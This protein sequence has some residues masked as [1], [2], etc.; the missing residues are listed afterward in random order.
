MANPGDIRAGGA[1][2]EIYA[3]DSRFQ[4][5]IDKAE[6]RFK[7]L[8]A[9]LDKV[10]KTFVASGVA[11]GGAL[12]FATKKTVA[13]SDTIRRSELLFGKLSESAKRFAKDMNQSLGFGEGTVLGRL[14]KANIALQ[15]VGFSMDQLSQIGQSFFVRA[16]GLSARIGDDVQQTFDALIMG[17][18]GMTRGLRRYGIMVDEVAMKHRAISMGIASGNGELTQQQKSVAA[19]SLILEKTKGFIGDSVKFQNT[20][21][22]RTQRLKEAWTDFL[23]TVGMPFLDILAKAF[24]ATEALVRAANRFLGE[25]KQ[26]IIGFA[27]LAAII[28]GIGVGILAIL[29]L[30]LIVA[31]AKIAAIFA[32]TAA[33]VAYTVDELQGPMT[34]ALNHIKG[35]LGDLPGDFKEA[36]IA[37]LDAIFWHAAT[38]VNKTIDKIMTIPRLLAEAVSGFHRGEQAGMTGLSGI[39]GGLGG[40]LG[41]QAMSALHGMMGLRA[42]QAAAFA[43]TRQ[44]ST[45]AEQ[46]R[47]RAFDRLNQATLNLRKSGTDFIGRGRDAFDR[48]AQF[49]KGSMPSFKIPGVGDPNLMIPSMRARRPDPELGVLGFFGGRSAREQAG[50]VQDIQQKQLETQGSMLDALRGIEKNTQQN[51]AVYG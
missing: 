6:S 17:A 25:N 8:G 28:T 9:T 51:V 30:P 24:K 46:Q 50:G 18:A 5:D 27:K 2:Y 23:E 37:S 44:T 41:T 49:I 32:A 4:K 33:I 39:A 10:A 13:L 21:A 43:D 35:L 14:N 1:F 29:K 15:D 11:I 26:L 31:A 7:K 42:E 45:F 40:V 48:F 36:F 16:A 34:D 19:I 38:L 22:A 12:S 47:Q 3:D 20:F